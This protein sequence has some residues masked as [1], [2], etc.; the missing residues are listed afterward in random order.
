ML[1]AFDDSATETDREMELSGRSELPLV[2]DD[3]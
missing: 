1:N 3:R 2:V